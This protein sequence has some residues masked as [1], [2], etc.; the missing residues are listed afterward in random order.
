MSLTGSTSIHFSRAAALTVER[1]ITL[2]PLLYTTIP[3]ASTEAAQEAVADVSNCVVPEAVT[4][5]DAAAAADVFVVLAAPATIDRAVS[6]VIA[7]LIS[8]DC[9]VHETVAAQVM[10]A[11]VFFG[12]PSSRAVALDVQLTA[13][14][15]SLTTTAL[16]VALDVQDAVQEATRTRSHAAVTLEL[17]DTV[18]D[19]L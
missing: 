1:F 6:T 8:A 7:S 16:D 3:L 15:V 18:A 11:P 10:I 19:A 14:D 2:L 5:D 4:L 9:A 12:P 17:Q 13:T